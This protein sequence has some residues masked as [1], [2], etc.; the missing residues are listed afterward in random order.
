MSK[1]TWDEEVEFEDTHPEELSQSAMAPNPQAEQDDKLKY[2]THEEVG[3]E[4]KEAE[5]KETNDNIGIEEIKY[6]L[7]Q[8]DKLRRQN[9]A[10]S[11]QMRSLMAERNEFQQKLAAQYETNLNFVKENLDSRLGMAKAKL[12]VAI[13]AGNTDE[14]A[15]INTEI[16]TIAAEIRDIS[17]EREEWDFSK[18]RNEEENQQYQEYIKASNSKNLNW[19]HSNPE[20]NPQNP[21]YDKHLQRE[22]I[23]YAKEIDNE[24]TNQGKSHVIGTP[25]YYD[26]FENVM[27]IY[28]REKGG[29]N[30]PLKKQANNFNPVAPVSRGSTGSSSV[31]GKSKNSVYITPEE[32]RINKLWGITPEEHVKFTREWKDKDFEMEY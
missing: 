7:S 4:L 23:N 25:E 29:E 15:E 5:Q 16:A 19:F 20:F 18:K 6:K 2:E 13:E 21:K 17:K 10:Q 28:R 32:A 26:Y 24:L 1:A 8:Y 14:I 27:D 12:G 22:F 9:F 31:R 30:A 11:Q 3:E